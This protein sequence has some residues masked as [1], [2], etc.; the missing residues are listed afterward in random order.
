MWVVR[1]LVEWWQGVE[2]P[3]NLSGPRDLV[4]VFSWIL[5]LAIMQTV[6]SRTTPGDVPASPRS[7][8][9]AS[10]IGASLITLAS[11]LV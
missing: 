9:I 7:V 1:D 8:W 6:A 5:A 10:A 2:D 4:I 3:L 11:A